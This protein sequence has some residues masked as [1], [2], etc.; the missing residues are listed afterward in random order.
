MLGFLK[1]RTKKAT[2]KKLGDEISQNIGRIA[3]QIAKGKR[4]EEETRRWCVDMIRSAF[5]YKDSDIETELSVLGQRVDIALLDDEKVIAVIECKAA[6]VALS[7]S[8]INQAANYAIA[9]GTEWAVTTNGHHWMMFH[10][11]PARGGEPIVSMLFDVE[12]L[13]DD[14]LSKSDTDSLCLLTKQ[15]ISSGDTKRAYHQENIMSFENIKAAIVS[16]EIVS[17]VAEKLKSTYKSQHGVSVDSDN[18]SVRE[19]LE[20]MVDEAE[21]A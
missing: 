13:D 16:P 14:G 1:N 8:A 3:I 21:S 6:T 11:S 4:N 15:S 10:V 19:V 2:N 17:A 7:N 20:W 12:V 5:G 18:D 9:L